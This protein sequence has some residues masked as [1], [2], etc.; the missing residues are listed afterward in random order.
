MKKQKET[1]PSNT[2]IAIVFF[3]FLAFVVLVSFIFKIA[4]V[5]RVSKFDSSKRFNLSVT[6]GKNIEII[7]LSPVSK[8]IVIFKLND[9]MNIAEVGRFLEV[10]ID[11]FAAHNSL[12]LDGGLNSLFFSAICNYKRLETNITIIDLLRIAMIT[13]TIS[14][15]NIDTRTIK[16]GSSGLE[17]DKIVS[18]LVNDDLIEKDNQTIQIINGTGVSGFGNRLARLVTN[19]GGNVIIVATSDSLI[20]KSS[21]SYIDKKTYT[22]EKLQKMLGYEVK[23]EIGNAISDITITIG[24]DKVNAAPF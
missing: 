24:E 17:L 16:S 7:S 3:V 9:G 14:E 5:V 13:K 20:N 12:V 4:D 19:M 22:V 11:G 18:H 10:P 23:K 6:N 1:A 8:N 21:I 2:K 15:S